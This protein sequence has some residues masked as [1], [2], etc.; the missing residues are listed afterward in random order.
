MSEF[1]IKKINENEYDRFLLWLSLESIIENIRNIEKSPY[2]RNSTGKLLIDQLFIT[3]NN[4]NRF[5]S[6]EFKKGKLLL[7]TAKVVNPIETLKK[8]TIIILQNKYSYLENSILT[9]SQ[10]KKVIDGIVF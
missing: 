2:I 6:C 3:G 8:E 1:V 5:I 7:E 10:R 9:D 4:E